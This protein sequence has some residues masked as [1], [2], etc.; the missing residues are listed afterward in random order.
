MSNEEGGNV[1]VTYVIKTSS[2]THEKIQKL[3]AMIYVCADIGTEKNV[4]INVDG[5]DWVESITPAFPEEIMKEAVL[6]CDLEGEY[7]TISHWMIHEDFGYRF[8][9]SDSSYKEHRIIEG[10]L[11]CRE[12]YAEEFTE[13]KDDE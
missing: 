12:K 11:F 10:R 1:E 5:A 13:V 9:P 8:P 6:A 4:G 2:H 7:V 3:L